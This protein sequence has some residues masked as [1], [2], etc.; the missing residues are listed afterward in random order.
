MVVNCSEFNWQAVMSRDLQ[1]LM[2][3]PVLFRIY[4]NNVDHIAEGSLTMF[5]DDG[6]ERIKCQKENPSHRESFVSRETVTR[7]A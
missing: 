5:A 3:G 4:I 2:V 1:K 7:T 6:G